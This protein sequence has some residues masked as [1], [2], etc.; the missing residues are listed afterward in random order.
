MSACSEA[1]PDT[2]KL[3]D[4]EWTEVTK[5]WEEVEITEFEKQQ[6]LKKGRFP[7]NEDRLVFEAMLY[8]HH[9]KV[10]FSQ[11]PVKRQVGNNWVSNKK[12]ILRMQTHWVWKQVFEQWIHKA[13][14]ERD[15]LVEQVIAWIRE[16]PD[17]VVALKKKI[18]P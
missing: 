12:K 2:G 14:K 15:E 9:K 4:A 5:L 10:S 16:N 17:A 1:G 8:K 13:L 3:T 7:T 11:F 18:F 6:N